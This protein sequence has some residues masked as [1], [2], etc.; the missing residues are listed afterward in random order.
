[1]LEKLKEPV[2]REYPHRD[3]YMKNV[4]ASLD[5]DDLGKKYR[6]NIDDKVLMASRRQINMR[7]DTGGDDPNL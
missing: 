6:K 2:P 4:Q 3:I 1:M 7:N 5:S